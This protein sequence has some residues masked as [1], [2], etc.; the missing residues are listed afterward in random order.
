MRERIEINEKGVFLIN[1]EKL[2]P[3]QIASK[4]QKIESRIAYYYR[5]IQEHRDDIEEYQRRISLLEK[6]REDLNDPIVETIIERYNEMRRLA[7]MKAEDFLKEF[8]GE[9]TYNDL[10]S[11]RFITFIANDKRT[12]K[13]DL[14]GNVYRRVGSSF[15]KLCVIRPRD[16]PLPDFIASALTTVKERPYAFRRR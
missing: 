3:R 12:Y 14:K 13:I 5:K 2:S 11:K 16:L 1:I 8:L 4:K 9:S 7:K 10:R 15:E 6:Q